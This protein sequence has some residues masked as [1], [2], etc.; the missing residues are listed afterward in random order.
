MQ[1]A[2]AVITAAGPR[3]S[4]LPLQRFVDLDGVEKSALQI[5][6]EEVAAAGV[7]RVC[8]VVRPGDQAIYAEAASDNAEILHFVEQPEPRGYGEALYRARSFIGDAPFVHLVSDHLYISHDARRCA[9]QLVEA[10]RS[11]KSAVSAVQPTRE[12]M[13]PF[14]GAVSGRLVAGH[15]D[16][17]EVETVVEKPTPTEAEQRLIVAGLRAGHY[18]CLFGMHVLTPTVMEIL[19]QQISRADGQPIALSPALDELARRERYLALVV[20]GARHNTGLKYGSLFAQLALSLT[21]EDR[22]E[23]LV[24]LVELLASRPGSPD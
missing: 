12:S 11:A 1:V 4:R 3:Q 13:L 6:V 7:E 17:Y 24:K 5:L 16:L 18:L 23:V 2:Q 10:A 9:R 19:G 22:D 20:R 21:G 8:V 15:S 14:Y